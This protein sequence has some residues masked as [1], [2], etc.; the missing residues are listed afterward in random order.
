MP[1]LFNAYAEMFRVATFQADYS[2]GGARRCG[3]DRKQLA[4]PQRR[5]PHRLAKLVW[6]A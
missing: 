1:T 4:T 6:L 3:A 5:C 2:T